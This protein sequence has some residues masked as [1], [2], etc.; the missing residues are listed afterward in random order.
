MKKLITIFTAAILTA[1]ICFA[2][3]ADLKTTANFDLKAHTTVGYNLDKNIF[4][5]ESGLDQLQIWWE[6]FPYATR[7]FVPRTNKGL[8]VSIR[9]EGVKYATKFFNSKSDYTNKGNI[10]YEEASFQSIDYERIVAEICYNNWFMDVYN[11]DY[12][13]GTVIGFNNASLNSLFDGLKN[14]KR[15]GSDRNIVGVLNYNGISSGR[16][17]LTIGDYDLTGI[18]TT[19]MRFDTFDVSLS[20]GTPGIWESSTSGDIKEGNCATEN[21]NNQAVFQITSNINAIENILLKVDA[22][23]TMNYGSK[24]DY[25]GGFS[26][27]YNLMLDDVKTIQPYFGVDFN[28]MPNASSDSMQYEIGAGVTYYWRGVD[29]KAS[30]NTLDIWNFEF[31]IGASLGFNMSNTGT[32]NLVLS[33]FE[34]GTE[35][36]LVPN[37]GGFFEFEYANLT[38]ANDKDRAM[39]IAGQLDYLVKLP[40]SERKSLK[41]KPYIFGRYIQGTDES[42]GI[43]T[44]KNELDSRIG[45]IFYPVARLSIDVRYAREDIIGTNGADNTLDPGSITCRLDIKL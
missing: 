40:I 13:N 45:V 14:T 29:C 11:Y 34:D 1:G 30:C 27:K 3:T 26:A 32:M 12:E 41:T 17:Q 37:L 18:V 36:S 6:L 42:T 21:T 28:Y 22:F 35:Q 31:P 44:D 33:A 9:A 5:M 39:F 24:D 38:A 10:G 43:L 25:A 7:G 20:A 2:D 8:T 4:G 16:N 23:G 15:V 19:G